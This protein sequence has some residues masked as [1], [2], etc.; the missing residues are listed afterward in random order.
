MTE[1]INFKGSESQTPSVLNVTELITQ[2]SGVEA[3]ILK[4]LLH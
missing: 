2:V 1:F 3:Q 4:L